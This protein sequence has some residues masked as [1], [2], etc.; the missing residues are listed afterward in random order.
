[1][2]EFSSEGFLKLLERGGGVF[3]SLEEGREIGWRRLRMRGVQ[4][5]KDFSERTCRISE[6]GEVS[7][8]S[9]V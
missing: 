6:G 2:A 5:G 9:E 3:F 1:M 7:W 8:A 4:R